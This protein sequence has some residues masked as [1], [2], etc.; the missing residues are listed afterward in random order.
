[1]TSSAVGADS[2]G[3]HPCPM[4]CHTCGVPAHP[5]RAT[6]YE[7][8][9][10]SMAGDCCYATVRA[11]GLLTMALD[12]CIVVSTDMLGTPGVSLLER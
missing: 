12:G 2:D 7:R 4:P 9:Q 8:V 11:D 1:M 6:H 3:S 10:S 5:G